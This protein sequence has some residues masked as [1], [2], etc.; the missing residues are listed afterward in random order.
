[1]TK[2]LLGRNATGCN[3]ATEQLHISL[4]YGNIPKIYQHGRRGDET[5]KEPT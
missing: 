4:Y 1:M 3:I 5:G 2:W